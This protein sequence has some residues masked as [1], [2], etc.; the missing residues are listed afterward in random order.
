MIPVKQSS[1]A[2]A[3]ARGGFAMK[4]IPAKLVVKVVHIGHRQIEINCTIQDAEGETFVDF[5]NRTLNKLD[6]WTFEP[7]YLIPHL[8][9]KIADLGVQ[10][11]FDPETLEL[12]V[13]REGETQ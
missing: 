7:A 10:V 11:M 9:D 2:K 5:G 8:T 6:T 4:A 3:L 1:Q 13:Y 12:K